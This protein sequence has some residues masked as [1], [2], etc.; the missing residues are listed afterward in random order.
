MV[1]KLMHKCVKCATKVKQIM[2]N[3]GPENMHVQITKQVETQALQ[4][5]IFESPL[6]Q[7]RSLHFS[8]FAQNVC[9]I[10]PKGLR[11]GGQQVVLAPKR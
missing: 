10:A 7:N 1:L 8:I 3:T 9:R 2:K 4:S 5:L 11:N 6:E